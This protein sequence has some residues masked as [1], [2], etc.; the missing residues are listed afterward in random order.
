MDILKS[1]TIK[2]QFSNI[3]LRS[4]TDEE[5]T[6]Y[7]HTTSSELKQQIYNDINNHSNDVPNFKCNSKIY[8]NSLQ[9]TLKLNEKKIKTISYSV[10]DNPKINVVISETNTLNKYNIDNTRVYLTSFEGSIVP[11]KHITF[12]NE[13]YNVLFVPNK[14]IKTIFLNS[15]L[16]LTIPVYIVEIYPDKYN[17]ESLPNKLINSKKSYTI[18]VHGIPYIRK[19]F[20]KII[21]AI[22]HIKKQHL[23][24][25]IFVPRNIKVDKDFIEFTKN[26]NFIEFTTNNLNIIEF[27]KLIDIFISV[28]SGSGWNSLPYE[29]IRVGI[30]TIISKINSYETQC[31]SGFY[32][33]ISSKKTNKSILEYTDEDTGENIDINIKS[34]INSIKQITNSYN[35]YKSRAL[36]GSN[37]V[38]YL[39]TSISTYR[40]IISMTKLLSF[41]LSLKKLIC[42][43][44][45]CIQKDTNIFN[46]LELF[47]KNNVSIKIVTYKDVKGLEW[48]AEILLYYK[49]KNIEISFIE[50]FKIYKVLLNETY[51]NNILVFHSNEIPE[52]ILLKLKKN[53]KF[54]IYYSYKNHNK[55]DF[56]Y[57]LYNNIKISD[58]NFKSIINKFSQYKDEFN[59]NTNLYDLI[60]TSDT[61]HANNLYKM[62]NSSV[63]NLYNIPHDSLQYNKEISN[64]NKFIIHSDDNL[65]NI[66]EFFIFYN[67]VISKLDTNIKIHVYGKITKF[68][69]TNFNTSNRFILHNETN[70]IEIYKKG[71][72]AIQ[73]NIISYG[74][75]ENIINAITNNV[76]VLC[77]NTYYNK[78]IENNVNGLICENDEEMI[79]YLTQLN[80]NNSSIIKLKNRNKTVLDNIKITNNDILDIIFTKNEA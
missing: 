70:V 65:I 74:V 16:K 69:K 56:L 66:N 28:P 7:Y 30:P 33:I 40:N 23:K 4:P 35:K 14:L 11:K 36:K 3:L 49:K 2:K 61:L 44:P 20:H 60:L 19:N 34:I 77:Y 47:I 6:K 29:S 62:Y 26:F 38:K 53:N 32:S 46:I 9:D 5:Y 15:E 25:L 39:P 64:N 1:K 78:F 51:S 68:L 79:K 12:I 21:I 37:W 59:F 71:G 72:I 80:I 57:N 27:Y 45:Y 58:E 54:L 18:G 43:Y 41:K 48:S 42:V 55:Y 50:K 67:N 10:D 75:K 63:L 31:N 73:F 17:F 22:S 52:N 24:L 76:P 8:I 13:N